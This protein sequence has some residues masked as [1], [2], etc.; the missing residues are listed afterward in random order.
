M[1]HIIRYLG[2]FEKNYR[3]LK[4]DPKCYK[5]PDGRDVPLSPCVEVPWGAKFYM[6]EDM[7]TG[8]AKP[9][10]VMIENIKLQV[11]LPIDY[12]R[13]T[14]TGTRVG[15]TGKKLAGEFADNLLKDAIEANPGLKTRLIAVAG[16][17]IERARRRNLLN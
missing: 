2:R 15:P 5:S 6:M 12:M 4:P 13:H 14:G 3:S 9:L 8:T 16:R 1:E 10:L 11:P 17:K 7:T